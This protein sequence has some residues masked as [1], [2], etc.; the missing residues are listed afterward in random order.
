MKE[1]QVSSTV[2]ETFT[3]AFRTHVHLLLA[4]GYE[5]AK[6]QINQLKT[7]DEDTITGLLAQEIQSTLD[8]GCKGRMWGISYNVKNDH[9]IPG[10]NRMGRERRRIDIL[11][12]YHTQ[13]IRPKYVFEAKPLNYSKAY[14]REGNYTDKKGMCRFILKGEYAEFSK[15]YPE[16][17]ML[18]YVLSDTE[19]CWYT[20]L[21]EAI[22]QK[23]T[24]LRLKSSQY[25]SAVIEEFPLEWVSEHERE[26]VERPLKI[27]HILLD[28]C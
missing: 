21:K 9:P 10:G 2:F 23:R 4:W 19:K 15:N 14:Q 1:T 12:E 5:Q 28:C 22:D 13:S 27:Y 6:P 11:I 3:S 7:D 20:R 18:G 25:D 16:V 26:S 17:G 24:T 8:S